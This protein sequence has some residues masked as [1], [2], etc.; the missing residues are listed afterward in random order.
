MLPFP[1]KS[2]KWVLLDID[3]KIVMYDKSLI[4]FNPP[5][6]LGYMFLRYLPNHSMGFK[7]MQRT[8]HEIMTM[9]FEWEEKIDVLVNPEDDYYMKYFKEPWGKEFCDKF[10]THRSLSGEARHLF[11]RLPI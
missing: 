10:I 3:D 9:N 1:K 5:L 11:W 8:H 4:D 7:I 2:H 6:D